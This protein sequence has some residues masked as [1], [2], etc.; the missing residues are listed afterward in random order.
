MNPVPE[1]FQSLNDMPEIGGELDIEGTVK[2]FNQSIRTIKI[3][4]NLTPHLTLGRSTAALLLIC[5]STAR[6]AL[7]EKDASGFEAALNSLQAWWET[8]VMVP[9]ANKPKVNQSMVNHLWPQAGIYRNGDPNAEE[10]VAF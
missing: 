3:P 10:E 1:L 5:S 4:D 9:S 6:A 7:P 8:K 2:T